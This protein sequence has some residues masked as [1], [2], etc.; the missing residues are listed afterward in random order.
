MN[1]II[2]FLAFAI[3]VACQSPE[4]KHTTGLVGDSAMVVCANPIAAQ[5]GVDIMK[6]GG[7][8][9]DAAIA[10]QF[11]LS[12]VHP[13]A[14]NIGGGGF[15]V[16]RQGD[17]STAALDFRE[18]AP[19]AA[20]TDMYLDKDQKI[21]PK[22]STDGHLASGVPGSVDGMMEAHKK[23]GTLAWAELVQ[24]AVDL[25]LAGFPITEK[26][27]KSFNEIHDDL[28]RLN[29]VQPEFF[30]REQWKEDDTLRNTDLGHTLERIRDQGRAGF[31][32]GKTAEDLVAEMK[33][34]KGLITLEDLKN[35]HSIWRTALTAEY[36]GYKVISMPP[37]SS[38]GLCV[39]QLLKSVE[40]YPVQTWGYQTPSTI[41]LMVEAERRVFADRSKYMGDPEFFKVPMAELID[42]NYLKDRMSTFN[43]DSATNSDKIMP[44]VI[45]G[46]ES[47]ETTHYSI[48]DPKGNAVAVTTTL[49]LSYGSRVIV[50]GS[51]FLLNNE[52][53]DFSAK[54][55]E[56]NVFGVLG[57]KANSIQPHK[58]MLSAMSPT[59]LEKESKLFMVLGS[60][61]GSTIITSVFQTV[62]NVLEHGM[63][64]EEAVNAPRFHSQWRPD[65][66]MEEPNA[67]APADSLALVKKGH[68]IKARTTYGKVD[69]IL[70]MKDGKL[71]GGADHRGD[72]AAR[73]Y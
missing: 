61:G 46:Y 35:Y 39:I 41:H 52:M 4:K 62:L 5:V 55:G 73:G 71:E 50:A 68:I 10:V 22:L 54:P 11:A 51:G 47:E 57:G 30:V 26:M 18:T 66:I 9:V 60:P 64:M 20:T 65:L 15:M 48:V 70:V 13:S 31:Y 3:V 44:G 33:R 1:K 19:A 6:K 2:L 69:A 58:R 16:I 67:I 36:K 63:T 7:N 56:P 53:D 23:Y 49:N 43:P 42:A 8:A 25:A 59:I 38:G 72:D 28:L 12:V 34:G 17:G 24:P 27:A 32:E 37:S 14:G 40:P 21:I 45:P 29:T